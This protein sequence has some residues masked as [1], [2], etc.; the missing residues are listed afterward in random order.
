MQFFFILNIVN[1]YEKIYGLVDFAYGLVLFI[2]T[3]PV[4]SAKK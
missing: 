1:I 3:G 2:T 4:T